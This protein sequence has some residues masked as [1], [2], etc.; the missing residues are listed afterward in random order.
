MPIGVLGEGAGGGYVGVEHG[1]GALCIHPE[2]RRGAG[3]HHQIAAQQHIGLVIGDA[4]GVQHVRVRRNA[5]MRHHRPAFLRQAGH[6][7]HHHA[8]AF[9]VRGHAQQGANRH[10]A[11]AAHAGD[12]HVPS[13][14]QGRQRRLGQH[15]LR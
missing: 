8:L 7:Q 12:E 1:A 5:H 4:G 2:Q 11:R 15:V 10:H 3:T 13:V 6:V 9:E 14:I